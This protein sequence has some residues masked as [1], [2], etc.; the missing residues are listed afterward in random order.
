MTF[1]Q[2]TPQP[3]PDSCCDVMTMVATAISACAAIASAL[4]AGFALCFAYKEYGLH[5]KREEADV[6][7]KFNERYDT[8][9][10][11][12]G[13]VKMLMKYYEEKSKNSDGQTVKLILAEDNAFDREL[14]LRFFEEIEV[15]IESGSMSKDIACYMFAY[16][17]ILADSIPNFVDDFNGSAWQRFHKFASSMKSIAKKK[18]YF[19]DLIKGC[20]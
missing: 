2:F 7:S 6:V 8:D 12:A 1:F 10:R 9:E 5:K 3:S 15:S 14:F 16:Y 18:G 13:V 20:C 11:I 4:I 19:P 17:A